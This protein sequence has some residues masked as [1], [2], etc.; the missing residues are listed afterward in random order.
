MLQKFETLRNYI[1]HQFYRHFLR[2]LFWKSRYIFELQLLKKFFFF[3]LFLQETLFHQHMIGKRHRLYSSTEATALIQSHAAIFTKLLANGRFILNPVQ[4]LQIKETPKCLKK[5][6]NIQE[7]TPTRHP[8]PSPSSVCV[9]VQLRKCLR[10]KYVLNS[11]WCFFHYIDL[12][13]T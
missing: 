9:C 10:W 7:D 1:F 5:K 12:F 6:K 2:L 8:H 4:Q 3:V 11:C 13:V